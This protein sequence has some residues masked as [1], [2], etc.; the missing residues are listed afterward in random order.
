[1]VRN[2][3]KEAF[4]LSFNRRLGL[5]PQPPHLKYP[6]KPSNNYQSNHAT[7]KQ[8]VC[9]QIANDQITDCDNFVTIICC[10]PVLDASS[11]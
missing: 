11:P 5:R 7:C 3:M 10:V 6:S 8:I 4:R 2:K 1:M 9:D